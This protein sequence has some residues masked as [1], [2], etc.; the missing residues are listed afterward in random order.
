MV[1]V[2]GTSMIDAAIAPGDLAVIRQQ[3]EAHNGEI[4]AAQLPGH[5]T[6]DA[7]IKQFKRDEAGRCWLIPRSAQC[8]RRGLR[9]GGA[10]CDQHLVSAFGADGPHEAFRIS[11]HREESGARSAAR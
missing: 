2:S 1:R 8:T 6:T 3:P 9:A 11:V 5:T 4:V 10:P 7:T